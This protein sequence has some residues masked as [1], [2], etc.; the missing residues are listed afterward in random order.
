MTNFT[1]TKFEDLASIVLPTIISHAESI[2]ETP[3][4]L[5]NHQS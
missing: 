3:I 1:T 5:G 4:F 2:G